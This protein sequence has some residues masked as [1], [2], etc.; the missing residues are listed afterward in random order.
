M[1]VNERNHSQT[2]RQLITA[3]LDEKEMT[4]KELS[5]MVG[6]REKEVYDHLSHVA[7]SAASKGK[8]RLA[9]L[10]FRCLSCG[11]VFEERKRFTRPSRCP[12]CKKTRLEI[13]TY[14]IM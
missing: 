7:R 5:Q 3:L 4:A 6:I 9:I 14:R 10:P 1:A 8:R 13:P 2:L 11:Y 12:K